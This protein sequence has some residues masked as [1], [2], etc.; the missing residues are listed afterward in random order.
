MPMSDKLPACRRLRMRSVETTTTSWQ[1]V[2]GISTVN[3]PAT[4]QQRPS[5]ALC[6][7][8]TLSA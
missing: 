2:G 7:A 3:N 4:P 5:Q 1:L 8:M 6:L